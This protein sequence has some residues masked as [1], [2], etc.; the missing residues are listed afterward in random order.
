VL[1][2]RQ[3]IDDELCA[4][5][6]RFKSGV[7][8]VMLSDS[9]HSGT[10]S[11][12]MYDAVAPAEASTGMRPSRTFLAKAMPSDIQERT[13]NAHKGRYDGIQKTISSDKVKVKATVILISG[14]QDNQLSADGNGNGL[15][16]E[17]LLKVWNNGS[18]DGSYPIFAR[19]IRALMPASQ[20]PM[21]SAVGAGNPTFESQQPFTVAAK[22]PKK[23]KKKKAAA[24][25]RRK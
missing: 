25:T 21:Y 11:R 19:Q 18:F 20:T 15:F 24:A 8:I 14:C 10:V 23:P 17:K 1:Y 6:A 2:D 22:A 4:A 16:T 12:A 9:C 7:R 13:Y 5:W 3:L